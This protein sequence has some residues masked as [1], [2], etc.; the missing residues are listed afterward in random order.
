VIEFTPAIIDFTEKV[1]AAK[2]ATGGWFAAGLMMSAGDTDRAAAAL[3]EI[4]NRLL[5]MMEENRQKGV[6]GSRGLLAGMG[7]SKLLHEKEYLLAVQRQQALKLATPDSL[8]A[9]DLM[10]RTSGQALDYQSP[11]GKEEKDKSE[12]EAME[13]LKILQRFEQMESDSLE[14]GY[15]H[16]RKIEED[17]GAFESH[18]AQAAQKRIDDAEAAADLVTQHRRALAQDEINR[19]QDLDLTDEQL[20]MKRYNRKLDL[21]RSAL[22]NQEALFDAEEALNAEHEQ[23]LVEIHDEAE[24]KK[25]GIGKVYR[26]LDAESAAAWLG[27]LAQMMTSHNRKAF[28]IGKAAAIGRDATRHLQAAMGALASFASIPYVGVALGYAAAAAITVAG[29][30]RIQAIRSTQFGGGRSR[31]RTF[32]REPVDRPADRE[33]APAVAAPRQSTVV[34]FFGTDSERKLAAAL[35]ARR[36]MR[37]AT[38]ARRSSWRIAND[39]HLES[40]PAVG[41]GCGRRRLAAAHRLEN[42]TSPAWARPP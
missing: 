16:F 42:A 10:A 15:A 4:G 25:Y 37:A 6:T 7:E 39:R 20:E 23:R 18:M 21:L 11:G 24:R 17:K 14:R 31:R 1:L 38:T 9:R 22:L 41:A 34:Q 5:E 8:D 27:T 2:Q 12:K 35:R 30:A 3:Q 36:S 40:V 32:R 26:Q 19:L 13:R 33:I 28:E 29:M